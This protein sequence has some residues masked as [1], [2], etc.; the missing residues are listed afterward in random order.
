MWAT[1]GNAHTGVCLKF[2][3]SPDG[4]GRPALSLNGIN[5]W[6]GGPGL[7]PG[8]T[9]DPIRSFLPRAFHQLNY[10]ESYPKIDF[11]NSI[12]RLPIPLLN[13]VWY[14]GEGGERSACRGARS[15][16]TEVW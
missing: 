11:F 9:M 2:K 7:T 14:T 1:Y 16:D 6:R 12:G 8:L 5:G 4:E 10:S 3:T 15:L 13:S